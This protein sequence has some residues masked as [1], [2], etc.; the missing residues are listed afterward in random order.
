M[1]QKKWL[2]WRQEGIGASDA[3]VIMGVSPWKKEAEL[4]EEKILGNNKQKENP[5]MRWGKEME[6]LAA[7]YFTGKMG[8][9]ITEQKCVIH[10]THPW[11]RATLDGI[12]EEEK[13]LVEIKAAKNLHEEVPKHYYP[14]LQHQ[15]EVVGYDSMYYLSFNGIDGKILKVKKDPKYVQK[16]LEKEEQFWEKVMKKELPYLDMEKNQ[17]WKEI[18]ERFLQVKREMKELKE[19]QD[20][21][22]SQFVLFAD[23]RAA[24][25]HGVSMKRGS[26]GGNVNE[27][28]LKEETGVIL[29]DYRG[30][31]VSY[32]KYIQ[33]KETI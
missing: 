32:W 6:P 24:K 12:N 11:M 19:E 4:L 25:G 29:D 1:D 3:P 18:S 5:A 16:L 10:K 7:D 9:I 28:K 33:T 15:M 31:S 22:K 20:F 21:L 13:I 2:K 17:D 8:V 27:K 30:P 14:Q 26:R 23:G